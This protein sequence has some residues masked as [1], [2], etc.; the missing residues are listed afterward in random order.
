MC[1]NYNNHYKV[2]TQGKPNKNGRIATTLHIHKILVTRLFWGSFRLAPPTSHV[3][4]VTVKLPCN[5]YWP[6]GLNYLTDTVLIII[7]YKIIHVHV[8]NA[9]VNN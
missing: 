1:N 2:Y 6:Q 8:Y 9:P 5:H 7:I 3:Q 4:C